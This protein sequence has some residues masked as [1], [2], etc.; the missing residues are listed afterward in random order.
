MRAASTVTV[1]GS[2]DDNGVSLDQQL[3]AAGNLL[4]NGALVSSGIAK[5][6]FNSTKVSLISTGD[7]STVNFTITGEDDNQRAIV[8]IIA[9]PNNNS[10]YTAKYFKTISKISADAAVPVNVKVGSSQ[11][12][13]SNIAV[14]DP[15]NTRTVGINTISEATGAGPLAVT[16]TVQYTLS[17]IQTAIDSAFWHDVSTHSN[18]ANGNYASAFKTPSRGYRVKLN[19]FANG[20]VIANFV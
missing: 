16:H 20:K 14:A 3:G 1:Q 12:S 11:Y 13:V 4:I 17:D 15:D 6:L 19:S 10:I 7:L 5:M 2:V 9:G 8:E 18:I